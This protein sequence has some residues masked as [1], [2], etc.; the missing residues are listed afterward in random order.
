MEIDLAGAVGATASM[1]D[2]ETIKGGYEFTRT[3][4]RDGDK[5]VFERRLSI[6]AVEFSPDEYLSL[7]ESIKRVEA[8]ERAVG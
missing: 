8:A 5:L 7:R 3:F 1:P 6:G 2:D 4:R